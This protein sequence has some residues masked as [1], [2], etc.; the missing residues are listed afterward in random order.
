[1]ENEMETAIVYWGDIGDILGWE[2]T[3]MNVRDPLSFLAV[4]DSSYL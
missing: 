4:W 2:E 3:W 1:M